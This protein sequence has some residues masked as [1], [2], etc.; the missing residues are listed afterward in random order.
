[1]FRGFLVCVAVIAVASGCAVAADEQ[2]D[3]DPLPSVIA[4]GVSAEVSRGGGSPIDLPVSPEGVD[5]VVSVTY[6][7]ATVVT[8]PNLSSDE[9]NTETAAISTGKLVLVPSEKS[10][11]PVELQPVV[12]QR[13]LYL[14]ADQVQV[15][16][17]AGVDQLFVTLVPGG[18]GWLVEDVTSTGCATGAACP[19]DPAPPPTIAAEES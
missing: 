1:M 7:V 14:S 13:F 11:A 9:Q 2:P 10:P 3:S 12:V 19:F 15:S 6:R 8:N 18:G 4:G 16:V 5:Q 17:Q